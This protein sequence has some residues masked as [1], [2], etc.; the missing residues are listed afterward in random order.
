MIEREIRTIPNGDGV[1]WLDCPPHLRLGFVWCGE[2]NR[3]R[4]KL[5]LPVKREFF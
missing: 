2:R 1:G 5:R 4:T 3:E